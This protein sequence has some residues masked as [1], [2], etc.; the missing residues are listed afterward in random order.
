[1]TFEQSVKFEDV[2]P[3]LVTSYEAGRLV[4]FIGAGMSRRAC[5]DWRT[6]V[7]KLER[8]SWGKEQRSGP[9]PEKR[10]DNESPQGMIRRANAAVRRLKSRGL[11]DGLAAMADAVI[12]EGGEVPPQTRAL[13][14]L[15]W[16]LILTTNY[17]NYLAS[18]IAERWK[19]RPFV[20]VGR[21]PEDCQRVL[22]SLSTAARG[23]VW[24]LQGFLDMPVKDPTW[25]KCE[26][27]E[28][29]VVLG[30]EEYRRVTYRDLH[31]RRAFAEVY[32]QQSL[33]FLGSGIRESYVQELFGEVVELHGPAVRP[34]YPIMPEGEVDPQF[35]AA[36]FQISVIQYPKEGHPCLED[37]LKT[38]P[39]RP[40]PLDGR[41]LRGPGAASPGIPTPPGKACQR[42]KSSRG[43]CHLDRIGATV[44]SRQRLSA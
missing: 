31:F 34:H 10:D 40:A 37:M 1:M 28:E 19:N 36:R 15:W 9:P 12:D 16:P 32:R 44:G 8:R 21:S 17:D 2:L 23:I 30:H 11:D 14:L 13:A 35:M 4:P 24:T 29:Q 42:W 39:K 38:L 6:L 3:R 43:R 22:N 41:R 27:L 7:E 5:A 26:G 20:C 33:L 18:S 25:G